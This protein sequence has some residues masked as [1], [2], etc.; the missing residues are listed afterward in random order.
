MQRPIHHSARKHGFPD[1]GTHR[2]IEYALVIAEV[3]DNVN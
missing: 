2:A 1:E 3:E